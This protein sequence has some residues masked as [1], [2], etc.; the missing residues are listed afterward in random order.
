MQPKTGDDPHVAT[1]KRSGRKKKKEKRTSYNNLKQH[2]CEDKIVC[3][4]AS[5]HNSLCQ[6]LQTRSG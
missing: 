4:W 3:F 2:L 6:S 1:S 5:F